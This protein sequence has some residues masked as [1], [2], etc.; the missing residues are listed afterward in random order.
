[1]REVVDRLRLYFAGMIVITNSALSS[2]TVTGVYNLADQVEA[3]RGIAQAHGASVH[4][5]S[6]W[7]LM[8]SGG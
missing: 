6:P 4:Q 2:R 1:M 7:I 8:V 3:L 5:I